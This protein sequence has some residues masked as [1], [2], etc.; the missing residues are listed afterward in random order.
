MVSKSKPFV[1][2]LFAVGSLNRLTQMNFSAEQM[3][4]FSNNQ[5]TD[6][7]GA[8][9][10]SDTLNNGLI[11]SMGPLG[12]GKW[13]KDVIKLSNFNVNGVR[14][15]QKRGDLNNYINTYKPDALILN[16]TKIDEQAFNKDKPGDD[17][18]KEYN[19]Y[20][21]FCKVKKGYSGVC[22]FSKTK[23]ISVQ[24]G[25]GVEKHDEEGRTI[26]AEYENFYLVGV[27]VPNSGTSLIRLDYRCKEWNVDFQNYL[28]KLKKKKHVVLCGD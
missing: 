12:D 19:Q 17:I 23:P 25:M 13:D 21:S 14:A 11:D 28:N 6:N 15:I 3:S 10:G 2:L 7:K 9:S 8:K 27:Y 22:L 20:W 18:P 24:E 4:F 1:P 16:E 5:E 26:T